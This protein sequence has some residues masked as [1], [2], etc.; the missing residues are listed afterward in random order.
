MLIISIKNI[1]QEIN[2]LVALNFIFQGVLPKKQ[3]P[4][5]K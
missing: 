4:E 5:K 1:F 2:I 3:C